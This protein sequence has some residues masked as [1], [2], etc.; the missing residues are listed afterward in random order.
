MVEI[1]EHSPNASL[2]L[3][4]NLFVKNKINMSYKFFYAHYL[5]INRKPECA[6]ISPPVNNYYSCCRK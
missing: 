1:V 5:L 6:N 3:L 4:K 2:F